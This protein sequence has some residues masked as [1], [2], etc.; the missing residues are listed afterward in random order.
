MRCE[1]GEWRKWATD[2]ADFKVGEEE[3]GVDTGGLH[4]SLPEL[5]GMIEEFGTVVKFEVFMAGDF[6]VRSN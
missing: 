4:R 2:S 3:R 1:G 5:S 6:G